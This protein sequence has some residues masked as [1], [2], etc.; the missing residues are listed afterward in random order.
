MRNHFFLWVLISGGTGIGLAS[1]WLVIRGMHRKRR[2]DLGF[3]PGDCGITES[4]L[5]PMGYVCFAGEIWPA[6]AVTSIPAGVP[7]R[8]IGVDGIRLRVEPVSP[9]SRKLTE[10]SG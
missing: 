10:P 4:A 3:T 9:G 1:L 5:T 7:V 8:L 2:P 6:Q